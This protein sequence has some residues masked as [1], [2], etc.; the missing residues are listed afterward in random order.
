MFHMFLTIG[1]LAIDT[2]KY[3]FSI[4]KN[5]HMRHWT[6]ICHV[7]SK[8]ISMVCSVSDFLLFPL[9]EHQYVGK[10]TYLLLWHNTNVFNRLRGSGFSDFIEWWVSN[11]L[12]GLWRVIPHSIG[13]SIELVELLERLEG[14]TI[15]KQQCYKQFLFWISENESFQSFQTRVLATQE[16]ITLWDLWK[17]KENMNYRFWIKLQIWKKQL[18][19]NTFHIRDL[20]TDINFAICI[21]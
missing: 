1:L 5:S 3:Q 8:S 7:Y 13:I 15:E 9:V 4:S 11:V 6:L 16:I 21:S 2:R 14:K 20:G 12:R 17:E 19:W 10:F 18:I